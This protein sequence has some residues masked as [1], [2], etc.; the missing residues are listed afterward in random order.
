MKLRMEIVFKNS[1]AH[2]IITEHRYSILENLLLKQR[3]IYKYTKCV[4]DC[5]FIYFFY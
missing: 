4:F 2:D 1:R 5:L 3:E